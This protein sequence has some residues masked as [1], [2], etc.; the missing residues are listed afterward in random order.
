MV[1]EKFE[2]LVP[3]PVRSQIFSEACDGLVSD[4][5]EFVKHNP[6]IA[7]QRFFVFH[8]QFSLAGRQRGADGILNQM[9]GQGGAV[10]EGVEGLECG[11]AFLEDAVAAL[12]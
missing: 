10:A 9:Q 7:L 6:E 4:G 11:D 3:F 12:A 5:E 1:G 8:L 2:V